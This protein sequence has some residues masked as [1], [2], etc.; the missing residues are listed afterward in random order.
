MNNHAH[1]KVMELKQALQPQTANQTQE[2]LEGM[3]ASPAVKES[4]TMRQSRAEGYNRPTESDEYGSPKF[5][6]ML[7]AFDAY[8]GNQI[9]NNPNLDVHRSV[10]IGISGAI[11]NNNFTGVHNSQRTGITPEESKIGAYDSMRDHQNTV[12]GLHE[13]DKDQKSV[14][15]EPTVRDDDSQ[16]VHGYD[17]ESQMAA[18][19]AAHQHHQIQVIEDGS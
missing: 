18:F 11:K 4:K 6:N 3:T 12:H 15:F 14:V 8:S 2:H 10:P 16:Y 17:A 7:G 19:S 5:Q 9:D 1:Q 13:F